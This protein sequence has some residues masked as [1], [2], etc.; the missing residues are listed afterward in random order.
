MVN[1]PFVIYSSQEAQVI[2]IP[3][4]TAGIGA[5]RC[6]GRNPVTPILHA[7]SRARQLGPWESRRS[8]REGHYELSSRDC[9][10]RINEPE[11]KTTG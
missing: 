3:S 9:C 8:G 11:R 4:S 6:R 7:A 10:E 2:P 1:K 5:K